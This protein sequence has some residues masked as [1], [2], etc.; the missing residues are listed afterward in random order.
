VPRE[1]LH[2]QVHDQLPTQES[3]P[4]LR[5]PRLVL[6]PMTLADAGDVF[7]YAAD[8]EVLRYTTGTTPKRPEETHAWLQ[9]VLADPETHMWAIYLA[10]DPSVIGALEFGMPTPGLGSIHYALGRSH[11]GAGLMTEAVDAVCRWATNTLPSLREIT[12]SVA[13]A[14]VRSARVLEKCGFQRV[15]SAFEVWE[16]HASPIELHV[17]RREA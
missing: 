13:A 3:L 11:W 16:R 14:N 2:E 6:R 5:T 17:Y 12:T 1:Q 7:A 10:D 9:A 15:G 4:W 8:P